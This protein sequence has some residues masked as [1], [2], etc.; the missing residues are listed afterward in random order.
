MDLLGSSFCL[1][2]FWNNDDCSSPV[3]TCVY[4]SRHFRLL[5]TSQCLSLDF[6]LDLFW[7]VLWFFCVSRN[8]AN[9]ASR[10]SRKTL[11]LMHQMKTTSGPRKP[12]LYCICCF[13]TKTY[14]TRKPLRDSILQ[15]TPTRELMNFCNLLLLY[16]TSRD[17]LLTLCCFEDCKSLLSC[18]KK[19]DDTFPCA[20]YFSTR[21]FGFFFLFFSLSLSLSFFLLLV[22]AWFG[23]DCDLVINAYPWMSIARKG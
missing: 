15:L 21:L 6:L 20:R 13:R 18:Q 17:R 22:I 4:P 1:V 14:P 19:T 9:S 12:Q 3:L 23:Q 10:L 11:T 7:I 5:F 16:S 2:S 8:M